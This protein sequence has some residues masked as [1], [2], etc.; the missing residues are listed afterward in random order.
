LANF[1]I[2]ALEMDLRGTPLIAPHMRFHIRTFLWQKFVQHAAA[3]RNAVT[4]PPGRHALTS[5][6]VM[7]FRAE[8]YLI[9]Y[10]GVKVVTG[11]QS[12][13]PAREHRDSG[14]SVL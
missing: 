13:T 5:I 6:N 12:E 1:I 8:L 4:L 9:E 7:Q 3:A 11:T 10:F 14:M 2:I